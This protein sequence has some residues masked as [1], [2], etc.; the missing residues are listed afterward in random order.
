MAV[1]VGWWLIAMGFL[2]GGIMGLLAQREQWLGGYDSRT[3]RLVRLGHIALI[4]LGA[5]NVWWPVAATAQKSSEWIPV[6]RCC[7]LIGGLTMGPV[8]FLTAWNWRCRGLFL[9]PAS[10]LI[11]GAVLAGWESWP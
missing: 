2:T 11:I 9:L 8:C 6:I 3:R 4:A 10:A 7:F 1:A 5:L